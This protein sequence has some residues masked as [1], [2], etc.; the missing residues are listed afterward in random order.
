MPLTVS[1]PTSAGAITSRVRLRR[2]RSR[3]RTREMSRC[4]YVR[5]NA[6]SRFKR[7]MARSASSHRR[8]TEPESRRSSR[9]ER[10]G[11][12]RAVVTT[13]V[14]TS[15]RRRTHD[16]DVATVS[17]VGQAPSETTRTASVRHCGHA[18][19]PLRWRWTARRQD[20]QT[21]HRHR[22]RGDASK[23]RRE[24][25]FRPR[26]FG[27]AASACVR[28]ASFACCSQA[29]CSQACCS[30]ACSTQP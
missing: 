21:R 24:A 10:R 27:R 18:P 19:N 29:C 17:S 5:W 9:W 12:P 30:Q 25:P 23:R 2:T 20:G 1:R 8:C 4:L 7:I 28:C 16:A 3:R 11:M 6:H 14:L 26:V 22:F 15:L 13:P